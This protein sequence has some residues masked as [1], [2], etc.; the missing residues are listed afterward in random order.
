MSQPPRRPGRVWIYACGLAAVLLAVCQAGWFKRSHRVNTFAREGVQISASSLT[1]YAGHVRWLIV[2]EH[3][4]AAYQTI[5]ETQQML[6]AG[7]WRVD[8][9]DTENAPLGREVFAPSPLRW[10]LAL[11]ARI[12][13]AVNDTPVG[14]AVERAALIGGPIL[15]WLILV[16]VIAFA[17]RKASGGFAAIL[18]IGSTALFPLGSAYLPALPDNFGLWLACVWGSVLP[19]VVAF[20]GR[21]PDQPTAPRSPVPAFLLAGAAAGA[22]LWLDATSAIPLILGLA[23]G[24]VTAASI[25]KSDTTTNHAGAPHAWRGWALGGATISLMGYLLE[26][27]PNRMG[28]QLERNHPLYAL[29][30][31]GL[32]EWITWGSGC[33]R[34]RRLSFS[35][36]D[37][38][39]LS[40]ATVAIAAPLIVL[41]RTNTS[42][43]SDPLALR[44]THLP[45]GA[46]AANFRAW[47]AREGAGMAV[48]ATLLPAL[49]LVLVGWKFFSRHSSPGQR[50][51][52]ALVFVPTV[53][54][55][56]F[57]FARLRWWNTFD[58]LLLILIAAAFAKGMPVSRQLAPAR[59]E[60]PPLPWSILDRYAWLVAVVTAGV[61]LGGLIPSVL[62]RANRE[63]SKLEVESLIER[64]LAH[65]LATHSSVFPITILA[66]P[67]RTVTLNYFGGLH[68]LGTP[69]WENRDG[70]A[71]TMKIITATTA[72]EAFALLSARGV[73]H[74]VLPS[75]DADLDD[76]VRW[77]MPRPENSFLAAVHRWALPPQLRPLPYPMPNITG[78]E[79][80][81]VML[82]AVTEE[83]DRAAAV[84]RIAEFFVET[85]QLDRALDADHALQPYPANLGALTA[86]A[87]VAKA[88]ED[89]ASFEKLL[90]AIVASVNNGLDR[91]LAW[92]RRVSLAVTLA[93]GHR[94]DLGEAQLKKCLKTVNE[95]RIRSLTTASLYRLQLLSKAYNL[96]IDDPKL[97]QLARELTPA[98]LR[99]RI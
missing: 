63:F 59:G 96:S 42:L 61:G 97:R 69:N 16:I 20:D 62:G 85:N 21:P 71:A 73:T 15:Q 36:R 29:A 43:A 60:L 32:G 98:E 14:I 9:V 49:F 55:F 81:S 52:I 26:F 68:G 25:V 6:A 22:G 82:F 23:V 65:W 4:T 51:A 64:N 95:T 3:N 1:G 46:M 39:S 12:D 44:L 91:S 88:R 47:L 37:V 75:W 17:A 70:V 28:W 79:N 99:E 5:A 93:Q 35:V 11:L 24:A 27:G 67:D 87:Q 57:A 33:A 30:W 31:I 10:W 45:E 94:N 18:A 92:D 13:R 40:F 54:A 34:A 74:I 41:F 80:Y 90:S 7:K 58:V 77:E 78:Y 84:S 83:T 66:P 19:L 48:I 72:D 76:F 89:A 50:T 2:P 56:G 8:R 53:V 38:V 86:R